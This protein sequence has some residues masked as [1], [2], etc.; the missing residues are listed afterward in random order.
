LQRLVRSDLAVKYEGSTLGYLWSI[1]EPLLL[2]GAYFVVFR[3]VGLRTARVEPFELFLL[4]GILPWQWVTGSVNGSLRALR[5]N[6]GLITKVDLPR[7]IFPLSVVAAK[8]VEFLLSL[9]VLIA[10]ASIR[11]QAPSWYALAFPLAF[12]MQLSLLVGL[13]FFLSAANTL[14]RDIERV[15]KPL[16][17]IV[18]YLSGI[19]YPILLIHDKIT[20]RFSDPEHFL[21]LLYRFNP[22]IGIL[23]LYRAVWFPQNFQGWTTV[24]FSAV[25]CLLFVLLGWRTFYRL[26]GQILKEL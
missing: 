24:G 17:R 7:E 21:W 2:T 1:L 13:A 3:V 26:E 12:L 4:S 16:L 25:G 9:I 15:I 22:V 20:E 6:R 19:L 18:F 8:S 11:L 14:L 23:E 5:G 10:A